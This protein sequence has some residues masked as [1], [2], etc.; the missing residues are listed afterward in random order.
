[1]PLNITRSRI[2]HILP[3]TILE[4]QISI[5]FAVWSAFS[6]DPKVILNTARS[7]VSHTCYTSSSEFTIAIH[8]AAHPA[9]FELQSIFETSIPNDPKGP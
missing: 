8:L 1:M 6:N 4:S 9:D 2:P 7:T 3:A 5:R